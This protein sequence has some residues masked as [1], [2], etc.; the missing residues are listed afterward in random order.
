VLYLFEISPFRNS[1]SQ[2]P[3]AFAKAVQSLMNFM[4]TEELHVTGKAT[5]NLTKDT[6]FT[7]TA[8]SKQLLGFQV[9]AP[10]CNEATCVK[11]PA[12]GTFA[13]MQC[14]FLFIHLKP[15]RC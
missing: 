12:Q 14:V 13:A 1:Q 11:R 2:L 7:N 15:A 9:P 3:P 6:K 4:I 10:L 8:N 5:R